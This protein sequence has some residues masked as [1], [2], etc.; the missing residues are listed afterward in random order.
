MAGAVQL[1]AIEVL[2]IVPFVIAVETPGQV[3]NVPPVRKA[4]ESYK[5]PPRQEVLL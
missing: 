3:S 4:A 1:M 5:G 2:V